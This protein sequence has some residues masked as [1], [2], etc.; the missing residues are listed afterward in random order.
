V[1]SVVVLEVVFV[2]ISLPLGQEITFFYIEKAG[3]RSDDF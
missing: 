2:L 3:V 1:V